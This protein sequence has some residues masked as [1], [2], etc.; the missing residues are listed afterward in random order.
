MEIHR[1][2]AKPADAESVAAIYVASWNEGFAGLLPPRVLDRQQVHR[3]ERDLDEGQAWW[4]LAH[5]ANAILGFAGV[6]PSRDPIDPDLGELDTIA[7]APSAWG[8]GVGSCLMQAV[9][10]TLLERRF[11]QA[12]V[13]TLAGY[14]AGREFYR[15]TGWRPSGE[16]RASDAEI[17]FRR[18]LTDPRH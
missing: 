9:L 3:W 8:R 16:T 5:D 4:W 11:R 12:I 14:D 7:V 1:R 10:D 2:R 15:A 6:G 13:W 17:A 18:Q